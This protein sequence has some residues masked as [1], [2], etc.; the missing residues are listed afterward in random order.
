MAGPLIITDKADRI[1]TIAP[2]PESAM[3]VKPIGEQ[4]PVQVE[5]LD[6]LLRE[7]REPD[8]LT[9]VL[10]G[11]MSDQPGTLAFPFTKTAWNPYFLHLASSPAVVGAGEAISFLVDEPFEAAADSTPGDFKWDPW[12]YARLYNRDR[13]RIAF[14]VRS[15]PELAEVKIPDP[16]G[17]T[18]Y[19]P[20][21]RFAGGFGLDTL[22]AKPKTDADR[23]AWV[24]SGS[25]FLYPAVKPD[26]VNLPEVYEPIAHVESIGDLRIT[27]AFRGSP[28]LDHNF[29]PLD[30]TKY[31]NDDD[32]NF[33]NAYGG[34]ALGYQEKYTNVAAST[35][36]QIQFVAGNGGVNLHVQPDPAVKTPPPAV[37][38]A[39]LHQEASR[40]PD[41]TKFGDTTTCLSV[42]ALQGSPQRRI[43]FGGN[44]FQI[45][46]GLVFSSD[47]Q[48]AFPIVTTLTEAQK[49]LDAFDETY[50]DADGLSQQVG[51]PRSVLHPSTF[52]GGAMGFIN[53][54]EKTN[55]ARF[56]FEPPTSVGGAS[57]G[58][59]L[60]APAPLGPSRWQLIAITPKGP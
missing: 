52:E 30:N 3:F 9:P 26:P 25:L 60:V 42:V 11:S 28:T 18:F 35:A 56:L 45:S 43:S 53:A 16:D 33:F 17:S 22:A 14:F 50:T 58:L 13:T 39:F 24:I 21:F 29:K 38:I 47:A 8:P 49:A 10:P 15:A 37:S 51:Q 20:K 4:A 40:A 36:Y 6:A 55:G 27:S 59:I 19:L 34:Y 46:G 54:A 23:L 44:E 57:A 5:R 48:D 1:L 7:Q 41:G 2:A 32:A 31:T 12:T